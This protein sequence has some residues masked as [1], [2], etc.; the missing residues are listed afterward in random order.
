MIFRIA[1]VILLFIASQNS[2]NA[3]DNRMEYFVLSPHVITEKGKPT[4]GAILDYFNR[5]I[6]PR[7]SKPIK[8]GA[9]ETPLA[10]ILV[11]LKEGG[12]SF[13]PFLLKKPEREKYLHYSKK[14]YFI[15]KP[16]ILVR[17]DFPFKKIENIDDLKDFKIGFFQ[18]G[19]M[20]SPMIKA[21]II[22]KRVAG[23]D[24]FQRMMVMLKYERIDAIFDYQ[25]LTLNFLKKQFNYSAGQ[26]LP[27]PL[28]VSDSYF[29]ASK[30]TVS[31]EYF[32]EFEEA[33]LTAPPYKEF[34]ND[35][36]E[37]YRP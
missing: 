25:V 20:P 22:I 1:L 32:A 6:I 24:A 4:R 18:H 3:E 15:T 10:R 37:N 26:V 8:W 21:G 9:Q 5:Y 2:V 7:L 19:A 13:I 12:I 17:S 29:V 34:V 35:Y 28:P 30:K 16:A 14:P 31:K 11:R 36:I 23:K 27:L 33:L